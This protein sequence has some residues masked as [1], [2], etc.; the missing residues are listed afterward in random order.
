MVII[1]AGLLAASIAGCVYLLAATIAVRRFVRRRA[2]AA[3]ASP[4]GVSILKPLHGEEP[5]L[6]DNLLSFCRQN[7]ANVQIV[8]GVRDPADSAIPVVRR[9]IADCPGQDLALVIDPAISGSNLK[10]SNLENMLG[11]AKHP[12]LVIADSDMEVGPDYLGAITP[13]LAEDGVGLVTCLYRGRPIPGL[14]ARLG[15]LWVNHGFLPSALVGEWLRP[16]NAC[17]GATMALRRSTLD[18]IG[19]FAPLRDRLADDY[20]LGE[21]VRRLGKRVVL[22]PYLVDTVVAEA[23]FPALLRHELRWTRTIRTIAPLGFAASF[24]THPVALAAL[25]AAVDAFA[26]PSLAVLASALACRHLTVR[27]VDRALGLPPSP[28]WLVPLRDLLSFAVFV[29]SFCGNTV[30]WRERSFRVD[31]E[32][33]LVSNG[34]ASA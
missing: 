7:H 26:A 14:A 31:A 11:K 4:V 19:G 28:A 17:F 23:S 6:Y 29:V 13:P 2:P 18:A 30:A 8:F 20:A 10:V 34:D 25:A 5:R 12:V 1:V 21:A 16:G 22:S 9:L 24:I 32:G 15:A 33:R 27:L 3:A